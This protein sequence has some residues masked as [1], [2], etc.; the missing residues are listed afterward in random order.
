MNIF[1]KMVDA[2][3]FADDS[4]TK[5]ATIPLTGKVTPTSP[6]ID[7][8]SI[9]V[10]KS[11]SIIGSI[12]SYGNLGR[13][14]RLTK[15]L[16]ANEAPI[17]WKVLTDD[18]DLT[19]HKMALY[20]SVKHGSLAYGPGCFSTVGATEPVY[21]LGDTHG[22]FE[23]FIAILDTI[24]DFAKQRGNTEPIVYLLGD[25]IDRNRESCA[26]LTTLIFAIMQ[27]G[28]PEEFANW[29]AIRLGII[30]GDHDVALHFDEVTKVFSAEVKPADYCDWL[31]ERTKTYGEK[32]TYVGR[33]W[34][35]L[36][37]ECPAAAFLDGTGTF[38][39]H[40]GIP[41][42]DIQDMVKAGMPYIMQSPLLETDFEWC[43]M[44]DAKNKLL[45][46]STKTSEIGYQEFET[47]NNLFFNGRIKNFIFGHQHP[48]KGF[49]RYSTY[50]AGYDTLCISSFRSDTTVGGPT[51][52]YFCRID[53]NAI[54]VYSMNPAM[55]VVRLEENSTE[56]KKTTTAVAGAPT[57]K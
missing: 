44:V 27:K 14:N 3:G 2:L 22:D 45:N 38:L 17:A 51:I 37:K 23:S 9:S 47:F 36:M 52:P 53:T 24:C 48:V 42:S 39:S 50:F 8:R 21:V 32:A 41:R 57:A 11:H 5:V 7:A 43:R 28:L 49:M 16:E 31:N 13:Y 35:R 1:S 10:V 25:V 6:I 19:H 20:P 4:A 40:G 56:A 18:D 29:N 15:W 33:A 12:D 55:Y 54:N 26:L 34:I 46:R 30:K